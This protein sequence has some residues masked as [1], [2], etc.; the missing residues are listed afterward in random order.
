MDEPIAHILVI[1]DEIGMREGC[2]RALTPHGYHVK[3]AEHGVEGLRELRGGQYAL[4]LLDAMMP[5][6]SGLELLEK[7][8][9]HDPNIICV[10]ITG[11]ATV[12]LAAQAMKQGAYDFLPKPFTSDELL[13]MV[14][15]G[16]EERQ[17]RLALEQQKA[18]EEEILQLERTRQEVAKLDAIESRFMLVIVHELRNP[19]GVIKNYLQLMRAGYVDADE[20]DEY[21]EK[22]DQRASQLLNMLDDLLELAHLKEMLKVAN[23]KSVATA[24]VLEDVAREIRPVAEA[25]GLDFRVRIQASPTM[26]AQPAHLKS[27]WTELIDNA[28]RY[29]PSGQVRVTLDEQNMQMITTVIDTG[30]G[31]ST[32]ELTR[33][34]QEFY[35]SE[36]AREQVAMGTGLGL[37]IVNQVIKLY[38]GTINVDSVEGQGSTFTVRLPLTIP[39][40]GVWSRTSPC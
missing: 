19:A 29:T 37:P 20:W 40:P 15:R 26:S 2:R 35:R 22:L 32:E 16:L 38:E 24:Q 31:I 13:A 1:D 27:L 25:K 33:I 17:R 3:T 30:I 10:M 34:F 5:G 11:Y 14:R 9:Q 18:L 12:D 23:L 21:L 36:S 4:I 7:I 39:D 6:M 8:H 28:I